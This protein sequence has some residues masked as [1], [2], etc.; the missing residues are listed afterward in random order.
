V[1]DC[2]ALH[3][4]SRVLPPSAVAPGS[5]TTRVPATYD[6]TIKPGYDYVHSL[7][8][9]H[10]QLAYSEILPDEKGTTC[11]AFLTRAAAFFAAH[12]IPRSSG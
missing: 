4:E 8:D 12:G 10:S 1:A 6:R 11:A 2:V 3:D 5:S 9:D 7:V